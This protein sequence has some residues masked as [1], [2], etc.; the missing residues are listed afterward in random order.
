VGV[1][2]FNMGLMRL[3]AFAHTIHVTRN[4]LCFFLCFLHSATYYCQTQK[5]PNKN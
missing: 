3:S 2:F 5:N 4:V 1:V